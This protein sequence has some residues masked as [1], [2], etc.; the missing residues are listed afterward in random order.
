MRESWT[1]QADKTAHASRVAASFAADWSKTG[2][3]R[4]VMR[5]QRGTGP[6]VLPS[7]CSLQH[8]DS[9][10]ETSEPY[11]RRCR[12]IGQQEANMVALK[13]MLAG[14]AL[15]AGLSV[16]MLTPAPAKAWGP[17]W[18]APAWHA[19]WGW[20]GPAWHAGW[21]W[22]AGWG[23]HA[24]WGWRPGFGGVYVG[25]PAVVVAPPVAYGAPG[26]HF[27]PAHY[28]PNGAFIP[29]HWGY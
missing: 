6:K 23:W 4:T 18:H 28:A 19:G 10:Y 26:W 11:L 9:V 12:S 27:I 7:G 21:G 15:V 24:G 5:L 29:A 13:N 1:A 2:P 17:G 20:H 25:A 8:L 22:R 16:P 14:A 3:Y